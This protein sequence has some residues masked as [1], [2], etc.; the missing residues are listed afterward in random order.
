MRKLETGG[1]AAS[2][3][4]ASVADAGSVLRAGLGQMNTDLAATQRQ[5]ENLANSTVQ[6]AGALRGGAG[7]AGKIGLVATAA[8]AAYEIFKNWDSI[9]KAFSDTLDKLTGRYRDNSVEIDKANGLLKE[10]S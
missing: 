6:L 2:R 9:T 10:Y 5:F 1:Q 8:F 4:V 3:G 7:L